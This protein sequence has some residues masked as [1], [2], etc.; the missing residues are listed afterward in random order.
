MLKKNFILN[1]CKIEEGTWI[2]QNH[3]NLLCNISF[4]YQEFLNNKLQKCNV[5]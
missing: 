5:Y 1:Y 2:I 4:N 3:K